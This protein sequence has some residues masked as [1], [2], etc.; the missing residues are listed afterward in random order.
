MSA[1]GPLRLG[2]ARRLPGSVRLDR[3]PAGPG[4]VDLLPVFEERWEHDP[5]GS[6]VVTGHRARWTG[7]AR[8]HTGYTLGG[9]DARVDEVARELA[10]EAEAG[11]VHPFVL[12]DD[13]DDVLTFLALWRLGVTPAPL[14][15]RLT[16]AEREA[17]RA[18]LAGVDP[19][20]AQVILWTSGTSGRPRGVALDLP[21]LVRHVDMVE[22]RLGLGV[23]DYWLSTLSPRPSSKDPSPTRAT[24]APG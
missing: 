24:R 9:L 5:D 2:S 7:E 15:P 8:L 18:A 11:T 19:Q 4:P 13:G 1:D 16:E 6:V 21:A 3:L 23:G 14:N 22:A 20:G 12:E 10:A 17:A